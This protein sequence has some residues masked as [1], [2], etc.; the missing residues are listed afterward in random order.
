MCYIFKL[1][2]LNLYSL[3]YNLQ[4]SL[5]RNITRKTL[6]GMQWAYE[7]LPSSFYYSSADDDFMIDVAALDDNVMKAINTT[8]HLPHFPFLCIYSLVGLCLNMFT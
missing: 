8:K 4:A 5:N 6:S 7:N 3:L 2:D 1:V